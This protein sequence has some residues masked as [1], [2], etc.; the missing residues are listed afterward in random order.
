MAEWTSN[1]ALLTVAV[2]TIAG[3]IWGM[4]QWVGTV[5][6]DRKSFKT[7]IKDFRK[8]VRNDIKEVRS[9]VKKILTRLSPAVAGHSPVQLT[10]FGRT[11]SEAASAT[12][13]ATTEAPSLVE[14]VKS[15]EEFEIYEACIDYVSSK[16]ADDS[17][18]KRSVKENAYK[19]GT[20]SDNVLAVYQV[21]LR[22]QVLRL[23][24]G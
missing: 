19:I 22:D 20:D 5:N 17:E 16:F 4:G 7:F 11:I 3:I 15:K 2:V 9:D 13:W 14:A 12:E 1:P 24:S 10:N 21:E 18:F 23:L 8:E 6:S